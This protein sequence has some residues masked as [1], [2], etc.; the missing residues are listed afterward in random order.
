MKGFEG[1]TAFVTGG[2]SGI[3]LGITKRF[4]RAGMRVAIAD[5]RQS[6]LDTALDT[7]R[8]Y[9]GSIIGIPLDVADRKQMAAAADTVEHAFGNVHVLCN[10][11]GIGI[12]GRIDESSYDDWD[13]MID[14]NLT[15]VFNG[16]HEFVPRMLAHKEGGHVMSTASG[17][18]LFAGNRGGPYAT[19]KFGVVAMMHCLRFDLEPHAV[20]VSVLC[21]GPI[22]TNIHMTASLRPD[23]YA[24][25]GYRDGPPVHE[26]PAATEEFRKYMDAISMAPDEVGELVFRGIERNDF[27]ILTHS[28]EP[29]LRARRD[30]LL[31]SLPPEPINKQRLK[32][33]LIS[34]TIRLEKKL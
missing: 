1:K 28:F 4:L 2:A 27:Y 3:G 16:V 7:L 20:G 33:D 12:I 25:T 32:A 5:V 19:S 22:K 14:V 15:G 17:G 11:A 30:A 9:G 18:G 10:N 23:R 8:E 6:H 31:A 13:W 29:V 26:L 21:P 34:R 24:K